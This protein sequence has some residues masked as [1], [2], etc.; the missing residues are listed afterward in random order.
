M[1]VTVPSCDR[2]PPPLRVELPAPGTFRS[3]TTTFAPRRARKYAQ[4]RPTIP[5]PMI[6]TSAR[7]LLGMFL[8]GVACLS[9][10]PPPAS[11]PHT[12]STVRGEGVGGSGDASLRRPPQ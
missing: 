6:A 5:A 3:S 9:S 2:T 10:P 11:R 12:T 1:F 4:E 7:E 8:P